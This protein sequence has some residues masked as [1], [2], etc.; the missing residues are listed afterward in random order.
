MK[1]FFYEFICSTN[2]GRLESPR[3]RHLIFIKQLGALRRCSD[4]CLGFLIASI[5]SIINVPGHVDRAGR[6]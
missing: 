2:I 1:F 4:S 3:N 6:T 5:N